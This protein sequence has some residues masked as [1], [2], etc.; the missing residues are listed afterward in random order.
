VNL[1]QILKY[2]NLKL[3]KD[4]EGGYISPD[5]LN[6]SLLEAVNYDM[7][8]KYI[9]VYEVRRTITDDIRPFVVTLGTGGNNALPINQFGNAVLPSDYIAYTDVFVNV[10]VDNGCGDVELVPRMVEMLNR[11][12]FNYRRTSRVLR[13]KA[14]NPIGAI[15]NDG[16]VVLPIGFQSCVFSYIRKPIVPFFDYDI[17]NGE[18]VYL[19]PG[20]VHANSSV[21]P[22]GT[23]SLSVEF[24][25]P[26]Q[27]HEDL[28]DMIVKYYATN[29]RSEFNLQA[30]DLGK[31]N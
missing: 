10:W 20:S 4:F 23:P 27:V 19:P 15:E 7:L 16:L 30:L 17:V 14:E 3:G 11:D 13:P 25:W 18:V 31:P 24:E 28:G 26:E 8:N 12:K 21:Q 1:G 6:D 2:A 29:F 5:D 22:V 9:G